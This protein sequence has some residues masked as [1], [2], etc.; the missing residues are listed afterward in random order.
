MS[1]RAYILLIAAGLF[2]VKYKMRVHDAEP[3]I[4]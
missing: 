3:T 1:A 2:T 4:D